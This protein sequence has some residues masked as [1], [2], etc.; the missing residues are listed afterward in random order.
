MLFVHGHGAYLMH[1]L[2]NVPVFH[3][4]P[5]VGVEVLLRAIQVLI[6]SRKLTGDDVRMQKPGSPAKYRNSWVE[7]LNQEGFSVC[8]IDQ[9]GC[10]FS[11]GLECYVERF[12]H[13]VDDVLQ[14]AR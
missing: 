14:F 7:K 11:E 10:G 9:Q 3:I 1:E 13:Y 4:T 6:I 8:G 12:D 2:L 5:D